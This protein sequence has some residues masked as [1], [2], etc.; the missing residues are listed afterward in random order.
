MRATLSM[1]CL[2]LAVLFAVAGIAWGQNSAPGQ[3][4][5][6]QVAADANPNLQG[7]NG[8]RYKHHNGQWWYW[9]PSNQ[10]VLWNGNQWVSQSEIAPRRS[11][12]YEPLRYG[13]GYSRYYPNGGWRVNTGGGD[14][15]LSYGSHPW[16]T[17]VR[18]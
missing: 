2:S 7:D 10:W 1:A 8:W 16:G 11:Y 15:E 17:S 12:A 18:R 4:A 14:G 13:T 9:L 6:V 3:S 5:A